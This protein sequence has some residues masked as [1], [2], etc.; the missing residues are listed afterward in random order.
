MT[1]SN[2]AAAPKPV[3]LI[4]GKAEIDK[5]GV[6]IQNRSRKL[7]RDIQ[8]WAVSAIHH[9][10]EHGDV[11]CINA[12]FDG[13]LGAGIR[14]NALMEYIETYAKVTF[15]SKSK[16]FMYDKT[17]DGDAAKAQLKLWTEFKPETPYEPLS[18]VAMLKAL[19]AKMNKRDDSKGDDVSDV[20]IA[21]VQ[22]LIDVLD[23]PSLDGGDAP[24]VET[25]ETAK[26]E[27]L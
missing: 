1:K 18:D 23:A 14:R 16:A 10:N 20:A 7:D 17:A 15:N 25:A 4:V 27:A 21:G 8:Q 2:E 3:V 26:V 19:L 22:S 12:M 9:V 6:S 5:A 11:T 24:E 13:K